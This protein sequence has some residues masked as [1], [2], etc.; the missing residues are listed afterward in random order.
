MKLFSFEVSDVQGWREV[1]VELLAGSIDNA[2]LY[3]FAVDREGADVAVSCDWIA[4]L[5]KRIRGNN[6]SNI[7]R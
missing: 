6:V 5:E 7:R 1:T 3:A 2:R 4:E